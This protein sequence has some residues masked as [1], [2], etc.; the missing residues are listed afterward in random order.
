[1]AKKEFLIVIMVLLILG[2]F[3]WGFVGGQHA[4]SGGISCDFGLGKN[5]CWKWHTN[6]IGEVQE[7][8]RDTGNTIK[9]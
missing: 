4:K 8:I 2:F 6:I 3:I 9:N 7:F 1:M 5:L